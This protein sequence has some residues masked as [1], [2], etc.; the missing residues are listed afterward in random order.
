M[1][2]GGTSKEELRDINSRLISMASS[3]GVSGREIKLC[4][5]TVSP[6]CPLDQL[7][8][9]ARHY[10]PEKIAKNKNFLSM[11]EKLANAGKLGVR[12]DLTSR[13]GITNL[14][15]TASSCSYRRGPLCFTNGSRLQTRLQETVHAS[16]VISSRAYPCSLRDVSEQGPRGLTQNSKHEADG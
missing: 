4:Y 1:L 6:S 8:F 7:S 2:T 15:L 5:V 14:L 13:A 9:D 16:S 3:K 11:L 12:F 10:Q